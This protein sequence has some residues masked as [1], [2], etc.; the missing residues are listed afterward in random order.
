[1]TWD[2]LEKAGADL[3]RRHGPSALRAVVEH[4]LDAWPR[5]AILRAT[6]GA[7]TLLN[8]LAGVDRSVT[9]PVPASP[10]RGCAFVMSRLPMSVVPRAGPG[11]PVTGSSPTYVMCH[12]IGKGKT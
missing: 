6:P 10:G 12:V 1:M 7:E 11:G 2:A 4:A 5:D 3:L 9:A 8:A